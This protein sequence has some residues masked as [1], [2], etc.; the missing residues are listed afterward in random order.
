MVGTFNYSSV[1]LFTD[2]SMDSRGMGWED[3]AFVVLVLGMGTR[4]LDNP[5]EAQK[6][7]QRCGEA[8]KLK[9]WGTPRRSYQVSLR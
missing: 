1:D 7:G 5:T 6:S 8:G 2:R 9:G 3:V 4:V